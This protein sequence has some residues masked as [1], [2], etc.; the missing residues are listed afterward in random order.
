MHSTPH[1]SVFLLLPMYDKPLARTPARPLDHPFIP[2]THRP[3]FRPPRR[4]APERRKQACFLD[5]SCFRTLCKTNQA[6]PSFVQFALRWNALRARRWGQVTFN[7]IFDTRI[8]I[9]HLAHRQNNQIR[10]SGRSGLSRTPPFLPILSVP[11]SSNPQRPESV[12][13]GF[14][15][16]LT[17]YF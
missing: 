1:N 15:D 14:V 11:P 13:A 9:C 10:P 16:L 17:V 5:N 3:T 8:E 2:L 6:C 4:A 12:L 7:L